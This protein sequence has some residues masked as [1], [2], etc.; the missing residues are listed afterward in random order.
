VSAHAG[1]SVSCSAVIEAVSAE[2]ADASA[3]LLRV[4]GQPSTGLETHRVSSR[5]CFD[6]GL[7]QTPATRIFPAAADGY[8][9]ML[10]PLSP[11]RHT[12][13]FGGVLPAFA[14]AVS[15]TVDVR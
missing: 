10:R 4:D 1:V 3:L 8:Y 5:G 13:D 11:G 15:Y 6:L 12:I 2:T 7:L 14:Q 9:A